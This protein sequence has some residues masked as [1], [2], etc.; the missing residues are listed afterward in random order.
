MVCMVK[1]QSL[2]FWHQGTF[3]EDRFSEGQ[4]V[5][6]WFSPPLMIQIHYIYCALSFYYCYIRLHFT[7]SGIRR[8]RLG[9]STLKHICVFHSFP[10]PTGGSSSDE[11]RLNGRHLWTKAPGVRINRKLALK[12]AQ[13]SLHL[14]L[15]G[16]R[17]SSL[18]S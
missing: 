18:K 11:L 17:F 10:L 9:T 3:M 6:R 13:L 7:S 16:Q 8:Q 5:G 4:G 12:V 14:C 2:T 15:L 1:Q